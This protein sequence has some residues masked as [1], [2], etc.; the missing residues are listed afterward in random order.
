MRRPSAIA[1]GRATLAPRPA[2][3]RISSAKMTGQAASSSLRRIR[4]CTAT[5]PENAKAKIAIIATRQSRTT[6]R[7]R[8]AKISTQPAAVNSASRRP[9]R[10]AEVMAAS[11]AA[12]S[13]AGGMADSV[14]ASS[15]P[16]P[17][18]SRNQYAPKGW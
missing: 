9:A 15:R 11:K 7:I 17:C 10:T 13:D 16:S 18:S 14:Q 2:T 8:P 12:T 3:I 5:P 1:S 6:R 4:E